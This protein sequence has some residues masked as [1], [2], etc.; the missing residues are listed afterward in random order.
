MRPLKLRTV[1]VGLHDYVTDPS[2]SQKDGV[3]LA[4]ENIAALMRRSRIDGLG[5][6]FHDFN[7]L[8]S[9]ETYARRTLTGL[10][11]VISNVGSHA[12]YYFYLRERL[13]L[14]FR[15][16]RDVRTA[17]WSSYLLQ[18]HLSAPFL[19]P[20]DVL[21]VASRYT[22]GVYEHIF[23]HLK[24]TK[25]LRCYPLT[26]AFPK[27]LPPPIRERQETTLAYVGRLSVDKNFPDL[28]DLL[29]TLNKTGKRRFRLIACGDIH[30]LE[31]EPE[32]IRQQL[33]RKL[34]YSGVFTYVPPRANAEIWSIYRESDTLIF[35]STSNLETLGRVLVEASYAGLPV[36]SGDHAAAGELLSNES[37]V[38]V[39]YALGKEFTAHSDHSLGGFDIA[40]LANAVTDRNR[41]P[42]LCH[43]D[44]GS[45]GRL[46]RAFINGF[47]E[48]DPEMEK[49]VILTGTQRTFIQGL[50]VFRPEAPDRTGASGAVEELIPWFLGLQGKHRVSRGGWLRTLQRVSQFPERT[51]RFM[52]RSAGTRCDY[53]D[54]GGIDMELCNVA[55]FFPFFRMHRPIADHVQPEFLGR[56]PDYEAM[57]V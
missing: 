25:I 47:P 22:R 16:V 23:P 52:N 36:V 18:E 46:L 45:H 55:E 6:E 13:R 31:C 3:N 49:P 8:L 41:R 20:S 14:D 15:I 32:R 30:S 11:W 17:I 53:T 27:K 19:R 2:L 34:G 33:F 24:N 35:P 37:L 38:R 28:V 42:N 12:H 4:H 5:V 56:G 40:E 43:E 1:R 29:I 7:R 50:D 48:G 26:V 44:Y 54:V 39:D 57:G 9:D 21:L 10:D 51:M